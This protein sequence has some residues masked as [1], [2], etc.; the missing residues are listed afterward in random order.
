MRKKT[1]SNMQTVRRQPPLRIGFQRPASNSS[2][3]GTTTLWNK[4]Q[5]PIGWKCDPQGRQARGE[6]QRMRRQGRNNSS[7]GIQF[8]E[9][10][11]ARIRRKK[12]IEGK[13]GQSN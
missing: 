10:S 2:K 3:P 6:M 11:S 1:E 7:G 4:S 5:R 9:A 12:R 13:Q 8:H